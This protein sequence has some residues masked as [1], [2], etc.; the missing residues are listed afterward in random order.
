MTIECNHGVTHPVFSV[1]SVYWDLLNLPQTVGDVYILQTWQ[2]CASNIYVSTMCW[3]A[4][5]AVSETKTL[6]KL[7][8]SQ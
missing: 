6:V 3:L 4:C 5:H 1:C 7:V 2:H 8:S